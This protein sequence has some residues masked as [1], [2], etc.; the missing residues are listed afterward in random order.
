M[1]HSSLS[2]QLS[3][4]SGKLSNYCRA[5]QNSGAFPSP[6]MPLPLISTAPDWCCAGAGTW[7]PPCSPGKPWLPAP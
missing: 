7:T 4:A 5:L 2:I 3:G 1:S 6:V